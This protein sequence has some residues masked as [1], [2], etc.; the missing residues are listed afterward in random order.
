M[1]Q[2]EQLLRLDAALQ[3]RV[4]RLYEG[5]LHRDIRGALS[6]WIESQDWDSAAADEN[7]AQICFQALLVYL[8]EQH[9]RSVQENT[10]LQGPDFSRMKDYLMQNF[11]NEPLKL[12]AIL[13]ECL[14]EEKKILASEVEPQ[15]FMEPNRRKL[16]ANVNE[17]K[18]WTEEVKKEIDTLEDL[19]E[20]LDYVQKTFE[21]EVEQDVQLAQSASGLEKKCLESSNFIT[22]TKQ[23]VLEQ[24][25]NILKQLEQMLNTLIDEELPTWK[26]RQQ[27]ACIGSPVNT[28]LHHLQ[29]WFT[30]V[31]EVLLEVRDQLQKL[32]KWSHRY[33]NAMI[34]Q[35]DA[36]AVSLLTRLFTNALVV[37]EQPV[38]QN[39]HRCLILKTKVRF[40]VTVRFLVKLPGLKYQLR[41]KPVFDKDVEEVKTIPGFRVFEF[42]SNDSKVL[43]VDTVDGGLMAVF[44]NMSIQEKKS[45]IKGSRENRLGVTEELH[46]IKFVTTVQFAGV[47]CDVEASSLPVV[48]ISSTNQ[49]PSAW[50]SVMWWTMLSSSEPWDLSLFTD[51]PPLS[52]ELLSQALSWQFLSVGQRGLDE[53][54]LATLRDKIE[55]HSEGVVHW[56]T[57]SRNTWIW[58][59]G[60]LDLIKNYMAELWQ[61]GSIVGFVSREGAR[62]LLQNKLPGTFLLRFSE[63]NI[64]GAITFSWVQSSGG[65]THVRHV[66]PYTKSE[67]NTLPLLN[68]IYQYSWK[69]DQTIRNPLLYLYPD[70]PKD[71]A[72]RRYY[73]PSKM[74]LGN[75]YVHR[76]LVP[77]SNE[78]TPPPSP[79]EA[80]DAMETDTDMETGTECQQ[81][82]EE[83][84]ASLLDCRGPNQ[85]Y[86]ETHPP[87]TLDFSD[88]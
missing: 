27:L 46:V 2:W 22:Q 80:P 39:S 83:L 85:S 35:M 48:V 54:Q 63:S 30:S 12:A 71:A 32:Q 24:V 70:I 47:K 82:V 58:I 6:L 59:D 81:V 37:E 50:V 60:I 77:T 8:E 74:P 9:N 38:M 52:W 20:K 61:D 64:E 21:S 15:C 4:S 23:I 41:V 34:T 31:A 51:P 69:E 87:S 72:F 17:L 84:F 33:N 10:I 66:D 45:R 67:L 49:A 76:E 56:K 40:K 3:S 44:R 62:S 75:G 26:R 7:T 65:E 42:T 28:D 36:F 86:Q 57:F 16:D 5:K 68:I 25:V 53:N 14:K 1:A 78:P 43:D 55:D 18:H 11:Q 13:W 88:F 79:P 73:K 29:K 19:N